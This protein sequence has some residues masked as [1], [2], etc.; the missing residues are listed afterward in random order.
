MR[1]FLVSVHVAAENL[2]A[3]MAVLVEEVKRNII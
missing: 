2:V 3:G 1:L